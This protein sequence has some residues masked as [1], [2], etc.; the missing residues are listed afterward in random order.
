MIT[1]RRNRT[2]SLVAVF[3][4][5]AMT[6]V[7][8]AHPGHGAQ[9]FASG[10]SHP[11]TGLDHIMAMVGVGLLAVGLRRAW[12]WALPLTFVGFMVI[13]AAAGTWGWFVPSWLAETGIA[14]SVVIFGLLVTLGA[15]VPAFAVAP[16]VALFAICHGSAHAAEMPEGSSIAAFFV[17][18]VVST[19]FLHA[20]GIAAGL[21]LG[22]QG[23]T[24]IVRGCGV[25]MS[26]CGMSML[27]G[28]L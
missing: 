25:A 20:I 23:T 12:V 15:K 1:K 24:A 4:L 18:F 8:S 19:A 14:V 7:A 11:V 9:G 21:K 26:L 6:S 17:G 3:T 16:L 10:V 5:L 28:V 13:G 2:A 22:R 27:A